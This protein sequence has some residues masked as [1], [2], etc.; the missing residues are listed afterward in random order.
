[1]RPTRRFILA[2]MAAMIAMAI[3]GAAPA[4]ASSAQLCKVHTGST[5]PEGQATTQIHIV[6]QPG[7]VVQMLTDLVDFLCLTVLG[8]AA[9]LALGSPQQLH[10]TELAFTQCGT[11]VSHNNCTLTVEA[12]PLLEVLALE[13]NLGLLSASS[14]V[15][16][17]SCTI[18]GFIKID[19]KY[20]LSTVEFE[21]NG[22]NPAKFEGEIPVGFV[23]GSA[24]CPE[25]SV[26]DF[27]LASLEAA[28]I[29]SDQVIGTALCST[30]SETCPE[31]NQVKS[32]HMTAPTPPILLNSV[33][34]VECEDSLVTGTVLGLGTGFSSQKIDVSEW[35]WEEC[36]TEGAADNCTITNEVLPVL[37]L[38]RSDLNVGSVTALSIELRVQCSILG[39]HEMDCVFGGE[40]V[41]DAEGALHSEG[42][43]H[44]MIT[45]SKVILFELGKGEFCPGSAKWD[46]LYEPLEHVYI[47]S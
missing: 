1:M 14:G 2:M 43:G 11:N 36:H 23:A 33:A 41:L 7:T 45:A 5:C 19:C 42:A 21:V 46:A 22:G 40:A 32:L 28:Y 37:D 4:S 26:L 39:L 10:T 15:V 27:A 24:L 30:H 25:S 9:P 44:G 35:T 13:L 18:F 8:K 47:V 34:N 16:R 12:L 31:K 17:A 38:A 29:P 3:A 20:D 6:N